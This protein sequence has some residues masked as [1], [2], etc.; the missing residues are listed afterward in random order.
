MVLYNAPTAQPETVEAYEVVATFGLELF[1]T[2]SPEELAE[3]IVIAP[4]L[5]KVRLEIFKPDELLL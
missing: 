2:D 1:D 4:P 3:A 5:G